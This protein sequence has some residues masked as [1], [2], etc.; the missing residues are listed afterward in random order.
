MDIENLNTPNESLVRMLAGKL[1]KV[2]LA[3]TSRETLENLV[4]LV[5][6]SNITNSNI[7][8]SSPTSG[9]VIKNPAKLDFTPKKITISDDLISN[10][11]TIISS[12]ENF[13]S[14][15]TDSTTDTV[16]LHKRIIFLESYIQDLRSNLKDAYLESD[17]LIER[18]NLANADREALEINL[19]SAI[20]EQA[21]YR[22]KA[23]VLTNKLES[24]K[25]NTNTKEKLSKIMNK[26]K[27]DQSTQTKTENPTVIL[28]DE[29]EAEI[30]K[31]EDSKTQLKLEENRIFKLK[32]EIEKERRS[33]EK[34]IQG[35]AILEYKE[36]QKY[37][38][39]VIVGILIAFW[40]AAVFR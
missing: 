3:P 20:E 6:D 32:I 29:L 24:L 37:F 13:T 17:V 18:L 9:K 15:K 40:I 34:E 23:E 22:N 36:N 14:Q 28:T 12:E 4:L 30:I 5:K 2:N 39:M 10:H 21:Y 11:D 35:K 8:Y 19:N 7:F 25:F 1:S 33:L 27:I 26:P 38:V 31:L 16:Q